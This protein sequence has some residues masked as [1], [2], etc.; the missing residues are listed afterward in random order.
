M[1]SSLCAY[2]IYGKSCGRVGELPEEGGRESVVERQEPLRSDNAGRPLDD[3][4]LLRALLAAGRLQRTEC[5]S[6]GTSLRLSPPLH[7][8]VHCF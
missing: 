5:V 7:L 3:A 8:L 2:F 4:N 6:D 1:S